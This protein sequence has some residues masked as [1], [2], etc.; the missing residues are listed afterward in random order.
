MKEPKE[1][2]LEI[3]ELQKQLIESKKFYQYK[4]LCNPMCSND[5]IGFFNLGN[6]RTILNALNSGEKLQLRHSI[7]G[8][9]D[10]KMNQQRNRIIVSENENINEDNILNY[11]MWCRG[12]WYLNTEK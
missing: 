6:A 1:I 2:E 5:V 7:Y 10:I 11:I 9:V 8:D 12:E 4:L 3:I